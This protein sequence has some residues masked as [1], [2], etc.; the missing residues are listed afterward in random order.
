MERAASPQSPRLRQDIPARRVKCTPRRWEQ[1]HAWAARPDVF[2][3]A[4]G[5]DRPQKTAAAALGLAMEALALQL[6]EAAAL[7]LQW[8]DRT[9]ALGDNANTAAMEG[10]LRS[11]LH[12]C[13]LVSH[14]EVLPGVRFFVAKSG[15]SPQEWAQALRRGPGGRLRGESAQRVQAIERPRHVEPSEVDALPSDRQRALVRSLEAAAA[16]GVQGASELVDSVAA[17][18]CAC[19]R[20]RQAARA[21]RSAPPRPERRQSASCSRPVSV[22]DRWSCAPRRSAARPVVEEQ[23]PIMEI[24]PVLCG[25]LDAKIAEL[26][27]GDE[28]EITKARKP[29][30]QLCQLPRPQRQRPEAQRPF[31]ARLERTKE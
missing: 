9:D 8:L 3:A 12:H 21:G 6:K 26:W 28:E 23:R 11:A 29:E 4:E 16:L 14:E 25:G 1:R 10:T 24:G 13:A 22:A 19:E 18:L 30:R 17:R 27:G 15:A 5:R 31:S 7:L 2:L 20:L